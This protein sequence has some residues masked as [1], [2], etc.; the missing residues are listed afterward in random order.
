MRVV[1]IELIDNG[2]LIQTEPNPEAKLEGLAIAPT[3]VDVMAAVD[4]ILTARGFP[5]AEGGEPLSAEVIPFQAPTLPSGA[6]LPPGVPAPTPGAQDNIAAPGSPTAEA[7]ELGYEDELS[8]IVADNDRKVA[9]ARL[10]EHV[11]DGIIDGYNL[12]LG[13]K[14][15][16]DL[17]RKA[18]T[19]LT[20]TIKTTAAPAVVTEQETVITANDVS[21]A[22][23]AAG[24]AT[25]ATQAFA[26][27]QEYDAMKVTDIPVENWEGD[28]QS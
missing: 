11:T 13:I 8:R 1:T 26:I 3:R 16:V 25:D 2:F 27:V 20:T 21:Q 14:N 4:A 6:I 24:T 15:L 28:Q 7:E 5:A 12:K 17:I 18:D 19:A 10:S 22:L 9:H 23:Q